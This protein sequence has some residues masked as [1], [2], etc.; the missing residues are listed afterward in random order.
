MTLYPLS[1]QMPHQH[2]FGAAD[3]HREF[4]SMVKEGF[5]IQQTAMD[6]LIHRATPKAAF[7]DGLEKGSYAK[8]HSSFTIHYHAGFDPM[9]ATAQLTDSF[10]GLLMKFGSAKPG[11][12]L[13]LTIKLEITGVKD[14]KDGRGKVAKHS[15]VS[16]ITTSVKGDLPLFFS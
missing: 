7:P 4:S 5:K 10:K 16:E 11:S 13:D 6:V 14:V 8:M 12:I 3:V 2:V 15:K 1:R 9:R